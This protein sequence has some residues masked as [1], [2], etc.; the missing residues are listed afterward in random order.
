MLLSPW[1]VAWIPP[2]LTTSFLGN[3]RWAPISNYDQPHPRTSPHPCAGQSDVLCQLVFK[4]PSGEPQGSTAISERHMGQSLP[5]K[6]DWSFLR[7]LCLMLASCASV[8]GRT[9][10]LGDK[11][12]LLLN[13]PPAPPQCIIGGLGAV[14]G[15]PGI[16]ERRDGTLC[17][18]FSAKH[19]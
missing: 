4:L 18:L 17:R 14:P 2:Y 1:A 8:F 15:A 12:S 13:T 16:L 11:E 7:G 6:E 3:V 10:P 19:A 5:P 9:F